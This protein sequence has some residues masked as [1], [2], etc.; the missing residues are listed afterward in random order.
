[1]P[2]ATVDEALDRRCAHDG[3][4]ATAPYLHNGSVPTVEIVLNSRARPTYWR[5]L[6]LDSTHFE[7]DTNAGHTFDHLSTMERRAVIEDL[8][9]L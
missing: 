7:E 1:V 6:D 9:T 8:K 4:W 3:I 5:R 2:Y